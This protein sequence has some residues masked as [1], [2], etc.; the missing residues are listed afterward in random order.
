MLSFYLSSSLFLILLW[1]HPHPPLVS[2]HVFVEDWH[3]SFSLCWC[4]GA[5]LLPSPR[6]PMLAL[7]HLR[8]PIAKPLLYQP[9]FVPTKRPSFPATTNLPL[10]SRPALPTLVEQQVFWELLRARHR[11]RRLHSRICRRGWVLPEESDLGSLGH[12]RHGTNRHNTTTRYDHSSW[13][14]HTDGHH[15]DLCISSLV[16]HFFQSRALYS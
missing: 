1:Y 13:L 15:L 11:P 2:V 8:P 12:T 4:H 9:T 6:P 7:L 10:R 16:S 14:L 3:F 5:R